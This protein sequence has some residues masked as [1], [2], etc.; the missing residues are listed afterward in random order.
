MS[1]RARARVSARAC[2]SARARDEEVLA[3]SG[4]CAL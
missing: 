3:V 4:G 1:A 2:V